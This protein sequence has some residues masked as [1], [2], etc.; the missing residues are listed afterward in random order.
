[1][2][3]QLFHGDC[4]EIMPTLEDKLIDVLITDPPYGIKI[5]QNYKPWGNS[6]E[7]SRKPTKKE[8]DDDIPDGRYF[9][10]AFRVSKNQIIFGA[11][12]F[13]NYLFPSPCYIVWDKRGNLPSV[14]FADT[15][16]AWTS[17]D[18]MSKK[19]TVINHG[20]IRDS[21]EQ[22]FHPTQK[23][24][25]LMLSIVRDFVKPGD[26]VLDTHMGSGSTG[27]ACAE[28]GVNFIGIELDAGYF[29]IAQDRIDAA[30]RRAS[31]L[32][33]L[34]KATDTAALPLFAE[35]AA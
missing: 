31:G 9:E 16:W 34:G 18:R 23:P 30:Y 29:A 11:N 1:M 8:W 22:R 25:P 26:W 20:F 10:Q 14:P 32:P 2:S 6:S 19:Y 7:L 3:Y 21:D 17:F 24:L 35:V 12:Y 28:V 15:E 27:V 5:N 13:L 33:K 4:L